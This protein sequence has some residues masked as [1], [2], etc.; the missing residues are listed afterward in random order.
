MGNKEE[1]RRNK[2]YL[3]LAAKLDF[4]ILRYLKKICKNNKKSRKNENIQTS[5]VKNQRR[6]F[7]VNLKLR[8]GKST[9]AAVQCCRESVRLIYYM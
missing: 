5:K 7:F 6:R 2:L 4:N 9:S 3:S 1:K 8:N